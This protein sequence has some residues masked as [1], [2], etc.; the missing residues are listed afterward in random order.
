MK[1]MSRL[2]LFLVAMAL[3]AGPAAAR[4]LDRIAI[5]PRSGNAVI[6]VKAELLPIPPTYR[7]S[8]RIGLQSYD[9]AQ[10][11]MLGGPFGGSATFQATRG[12]VVDGYMAIEVRPGTYAFRDLSR[13]DYWALCFNDGSLQFTVAAGE[14]LYL[15]EMDVRLHVRELERMAV[16]SGRISTSSGAVHFFDGVTP[17]ALAPVDEAALAAAAAWVR[18]RMPRTTVA[19]RAAQF[20]PARFG[21]GNDL[22][23]LSRICGGYYQ[24]RARPRADAAKPATGR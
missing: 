12:N 1:I 19:P 5:T 8:Y 23:G 18:T 11:R 3:G 2:G 10:Q 13:Q 4:N 16:M 20:T 14:V 7:T 6:L 15:G 17:P 24:G 9:P 21:T 22:F